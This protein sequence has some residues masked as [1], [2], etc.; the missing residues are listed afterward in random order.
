MSAS[1]A[2]Q[3]GMVPATDPAARDWHRWGAFGFAALVYL[4]LYSPIVVMAIFSFN[5]NSVQN[6]P[7]KGFTTIWYQNLAEDTEMLDAVMFSFKVSVL[8]VLVSSIVGTGFAMLFTRVKMRGSSILEAMVALPFVMPGM[9]LGISLLLTMRVIGIQPGFLAIVIGHVVFITPIILFVVG[10]RL[11]TLDPTLEQA[12][13]DLGA[14][15]IRTFLNVTF[16]SIRTALLAAALLGFTISFDEIIVTFFLAGSDP[17]LPVYIWTL[18]RQGFSPS[19]NA[20]LTIIALVSI[21][22]IT[23]A[24][25]TVFRN[26]DKGQG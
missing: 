11:R 19:V 21:A 12:S 20:I 7:L 10:Q 22:V 8:A 24:A 15:S 16:P 25:S 1:P 9:V 3:P 5:D 14:G 23:F 26:R 6:L 4:F 13:K 18:L 2:N 17:T